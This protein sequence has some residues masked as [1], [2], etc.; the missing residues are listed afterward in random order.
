[1]LTCQVSMNVDNL[2]F[3]CMKARKIY[4]DIFIKSEK[5]HKVHSRNCSY[6][7]EKF[8]PR[9]AATIYCSRDCQKKNKI[10]KENIAWLKSINKKPRLIFGYKETIVL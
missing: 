2:A 9:N 1:M 5:K 4:K 6:C 10:K 7:K 3:L 8:N